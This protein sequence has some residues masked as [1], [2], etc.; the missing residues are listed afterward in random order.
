MKICNYNELDE[1]VQ[2][3]EELNHS[4]SEMVGFNKQISQ[5]QEQY[6]DNTTKVKEEIT[7]DPRW[8]EWVAKTQE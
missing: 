5:I 3:N 4:Y 2:A 7:A 1:F 6:G 8:S